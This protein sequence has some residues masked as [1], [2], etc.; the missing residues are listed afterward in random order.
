V[1]EAPKAPPSG[2][3][4]RHVLALDGGGVRGIVTLRMLEAFEERFGV[5]A[6]D[7]FDFF[8]GTSTG[9][10]IAALLAFR[11]L[12]AR[13]ILDLYRDLAGRVFQWS[14][15]SSR[16]GRLF[17]R[18]MYSR[19]FAEGKLVELF[20]ETRLGELASGARGPRGIMLTTHDIVRN[21]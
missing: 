11:D 18:V 13:E 16:I 9:A 4:R 19:E 1:G 21:E 2:D 6:G 7:F 3:G 8:A 17:S 15:S 5:A 20:G 12:S 14:L 10:I